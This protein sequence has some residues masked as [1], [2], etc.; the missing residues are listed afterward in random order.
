MYTSLLNSYIKV[1]PK[2]NENVVNVTQDNIKILPPGINK[3]E[4][5]FSVEGNNIRMGIGQ[6]QDSMK[7]HRQSL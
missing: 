1:R 3:S 2:L 4:A 6:T 7:K 5:L